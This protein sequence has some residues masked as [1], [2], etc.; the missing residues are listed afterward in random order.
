VTSIQCR[1]RDIVG[2]FASRGFSL[3]EME[4]WRKV[5]RRRMQA[6]QTGRTHPLPSA[7]VSGATS[8]GPQGRRGHEV[9]R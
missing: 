5:T 1:G 6:S 4:I 3:S 8:R 7:S 9:G 2:S